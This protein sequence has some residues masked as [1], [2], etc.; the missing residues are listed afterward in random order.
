MIRSAPLTALVLFIAAGSAAAQVTI[1]GTVTDPAGNPVAGADLDLFDAQNGTKLDLGGQDDNTDASGFYS[2]TVSPD[3]YHVRAEPPL[4]RDDLAPVQHRDLTAATDLTVDFTLPRGSRVS[5]RVTGADGQPVAGTDLDLVDPLTGIKAATVRDDTDADG[6]FAFTVIPGTWHVAFGPPR[7]SGAGPLRI[8]AV[9]LGTDR[10][11]DIAL[12]RGHLL[13]GTVKSSG[14][15]AIFR[16]DLD[17]RDRTTRRPVPTTDDATDF[18]GVLDVL[19]PEGHLDLFVVPPR[20]A[21]FA[22]YAAYGINVTGDLDLGDVVLPDGHVLSGTARD[23][24]G[25]ALAGADLDFF[26]AGLCD[27]Y[28]LVDGVTDGA[29]NFSTRV[30][31]GVYDVL[32][33]PTAGNGSPWLVESVSVVGDV[34]QDLSATGAT[35]VVEAASRILDA[36]GAPVPNVT[37]EAVPLESGTAWTAVTDDAGEFRM[38]ATAG[39]YAVTLTSDTATMT[40]ARVCLPCGFPEQVTLASP[41]VIAGRRRLEAWPNPWN[42]ATEFSVALDDGS[43]SARLD[44]YD[45]AGRRVR[46]LHRGPIQRGIATFRWDGNDDAGRP[47]TSGIYF[48]RFRDASGTRTAKT[49]RITP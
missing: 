46:R 9:D 20:T 39:A 21:P 25:A 35:T 17:A 23:G 27:P 48:V 34:T 28:P 43:N 49:A 19:L 14:G 1:Q 37:V 41:A 4:N 38:D 2:L 40:L 24:S 13:H 26:Q 18:N 31:P 16:A 22:P 11:L 29:G 15:N 6:R 42:D 36:D 12:P 44:V 7:G 30:A 10:V 32:V 8:D 33:V 47:V 45:L 5:G 3:I